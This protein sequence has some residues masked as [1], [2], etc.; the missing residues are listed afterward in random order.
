MFSQTFSKHLAQGRRNRSGWSGQNRAISVKIIATTNAICMKCGNDHHHI[1]GDIELIISA[2][3]WQ[4]KLAI[5][6]VASLYT[7]DREIFAVKNISSVS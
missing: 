2:G 4:R 6:L 5:V 3:V 1:L 7:V